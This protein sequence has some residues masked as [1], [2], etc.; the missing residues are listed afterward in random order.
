MGDRSIT[1]AWIGATGH[2]IE[3]LGLF[4]PGAD[5]RDVI[6]EVEAGIEIET[7]TA[8]ALV[9]RSRCRAGNR[10]VLHRERTGLF[11]VA[12][13]GAVVTFLRFYAR[14]QYALACRL[15]PG[16]DPPTTVE[17]PWAGDRELSPSCTRTDPGNVRVS[18]GARARTGLTRPEIAA[19][20][21]AEIDAGALLPAGSWTYA[22]NPIDGIVMVAGVPVAVVLLPHQILVG[23]PTESTETAKARQ[24]AERVAREL[25]QAADLL[26]SHG[27]TVTPP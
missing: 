17:P 25:Q 23:V 27:W 12:E 8:V 6:R 18:A 20:V 13:G 14:E 22:S 11:V 2:A 10:Y 16:G 7:G 15:W 19:L 5:G 4:Y 24:A 1:S 21:L 3:A 9:G 26:R